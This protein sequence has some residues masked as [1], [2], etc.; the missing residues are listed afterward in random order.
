MEIAL[1]GSWCPALVKPWPGNKDEGRFEVT[2]NEADKYMFKVPTLRNVT[3]TGP[4]LHDG[5]ISDLKKLTSM[6][7]E[8]QLGRTLDD[9]QVE[10]IVTFLKAL[11]G[12]LPKELIEAPK[13]PA[14]G[15][16][17]PKPKEN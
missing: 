10:S 9:T 3:K 6:M 12:E 13:L 8:H 14:D 15:P 17:T 5:S 11:T 7:A 16:D 1:G 2:K 4:Y